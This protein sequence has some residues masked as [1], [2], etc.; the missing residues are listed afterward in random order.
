VLSEWF[1]G[2][3]QGPVQLNLGRLRQFKSGVLYIEASAK[4]KNSPQMFE[5]HSSVSKL[6]VKEGFLDKAAGNS[7]NPHVTVAKFS[8]LKRGRKD[9]RKVKLKKFPLESYKTHMECNVGCVDVRSLQLC[10]MVGRKKGKYY[11]VV[12]SFDL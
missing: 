8:K 11:N 5:L 6:L 3:A 2:N 10:S 1:A 7:F 9:K 4:D 12:K